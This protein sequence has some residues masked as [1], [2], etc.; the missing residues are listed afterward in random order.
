MASPSRLVQD[1]RIELDVLVRLNEKEIRALEGLVGYG[2]DTFLKVFYANMPTTYLKPHE[3]GLRSLFKTIR[4]DLRPI[5][6]RVDS[7]RRAFALDD[8]VIRSREDH[9]ALIALHGSFTRD[10]DLVAVPWTEHV[11]NMELLVHEIEYRTGLK[12]QG[13]PS[14]KPHGRKAFSLLFPG[15]EDPRWVDL[16]VLPKL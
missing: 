14:D 10:L 1:P 7:A 13:P 12:R 3:A 2:I 11:S 5:L 15:F 8:P 9:D 6:N 4:T 16:S